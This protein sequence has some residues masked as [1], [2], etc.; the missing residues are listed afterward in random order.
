M[1]VDAKEELPASTA[2]KAEDV[3][4]VAKA[5]VALKEMASP[6]LWKEEI[7]GALTI[8]L[9]YPTDVTAVGI[10]GFTVIKEVTLKRALWKHRR[11][12]SRRAPQGA[13]SLDMDTALLAELSGIPEPIF[14]ELD[15]RDLGVLQMALGKLVYSPRV[16]SEN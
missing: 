2:A 5:E 7:G 1:T 13:T 11:A 14:D 8:T 6:S 4:T 16:L 9:E 3:N 12:A 15:A 10:P